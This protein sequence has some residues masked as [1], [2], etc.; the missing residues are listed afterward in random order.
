MVKFSTYYVC[1]CVCVCVYVHVTVNECKV[2]L[3]KNCPF[4]V[5]T[6]VEPKHIRSH[7]TVTVSSGMCFD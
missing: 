6:T 3:P 4:I 1:V 7:F 2:A 5:N